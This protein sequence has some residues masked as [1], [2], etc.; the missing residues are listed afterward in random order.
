MTNIRQQKAELRLIET[1][2]YFNAQV[3][4]IQEIE[5]SA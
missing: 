1:I 2:D 5:V 3:L 4:A